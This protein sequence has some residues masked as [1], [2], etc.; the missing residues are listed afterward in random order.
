VFVIL[1][2]SRYG[3]CQSIKSIEAR[4]CA[5]NVSYDQ[6]TGVT[7]QK[8]RARRRRR[9]RLRRREG[10]V[11]SDGAVIAYDLCIIDHPLDFFTSQRRTEQK[12]RVGSA[13]QS[14][15]LY[16]D[17]LMTKIFF[18]VSMVDLCFARMLIMTKGPGEA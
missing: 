9:R 10:I 7:S 15:S 5:I 11:K 8:D 13:R 18:T 6:E 17:H 1:P 14:A 12:E 2:W 16:N 3:S 4:H